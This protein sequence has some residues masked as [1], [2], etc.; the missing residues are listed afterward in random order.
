M[1]DKIDAEKL[2]FEADAC[3]AKEL[4]FCHPL[5]IRFKAIRDEHFA[6]LVLEEAAKVCDDMARRTY[7]NTAAVHAG[8]L[9]PP[10]IPWANRDL[11]S[12]TFGA[13]DGPQCQER[14][15]VGRLY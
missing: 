15:G 7:S 9:G 11:S 13:I 14:R 6:R 3:A 12:N 5:S 4:P 1:P 8:L 2:G 10:M